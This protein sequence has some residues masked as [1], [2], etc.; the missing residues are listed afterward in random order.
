MYTPV[1]V[2]D[3][4]QINGVWYQNYNV[5]DSTGAIVEK[6][7][8]HNGAQWV[9]AP[10]KIDLTK[11]IPST[12]SGINLKKSV[13]NLDKCLVDLSKKSGIDMAI[14]CARVACVMDFSGSMRQLYNTGAVQRVLDRLMPL[15]LRFDDNGAVD[16]WLFHNEYKRIDSITLDNFDGY[17]DNVA[18][19]SGMRFGGTSYAP[20][21][22]DVYSKYIIE[23]PSRVPAFVIF[24]TDGSN[25]DKG[26][27][28]NIIKRLSEYNVFV[29]F[30][31]IGN[32]SFD[33]LHRLDDLKG[34]R[35]DNTG[36]I[37]VADFDKLTDDELYRELLVQYIDWLNVL[38][39]K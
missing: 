4:Y 14:H 8:M 9:E 27:T 2:S 1:P 23:E 15:G 16:M 17:V 26:N 10:S 6:R 7:Y 35:A 31:G 20:A 12:N 13:I 21:L 11:K 37:K 5:Q 25:S 34:R 30:V 38:G 32:D 33:Y 24:I 29:Q 28:N 3:A 18:L 22:N 19:K 39:I 36:F